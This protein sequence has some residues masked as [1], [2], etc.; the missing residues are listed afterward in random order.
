MRLRIP[1][2]V[3]PDDSNFR[4]IRRPHRDMHYA[5]AVHFPQ[6]GAELFIGAKVRA[7]AK[8]VQVVIG[9]QK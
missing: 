8:K 9:Q 1:P 3:L 4:G 7:F 6:V 2:V 5:A